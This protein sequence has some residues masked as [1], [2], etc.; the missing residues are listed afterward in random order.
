M[1]TNTAWGIQVC[2]CWKLIFTHA[3]Y[4]LLHHS[5]CPSGLASDTPK[6]RDFMLMYLQSETTL[7]SSGK[8][9]FHSHFSLEVPGVRLTGTPI[10][11]AILQLWLP[12][13]EDLYWISRVLSKKQ[14]FSCFPRIMRVSDIFFPFAVGLLFCQDGWTWQAWNKENQPS[15]P[16]SLP[17]D[18]LNTSVTKSLTPSQSSSI[19]NFPEIRQEFTWECQVRDST[20]CRNNGETWK[21]MMESW[22]R[23]P[24]HSDYAVAEHLT[25]EWLLKLCGQG[26][27]R[28]PCPWARHSGTMTHML[29]LWNRLV[30]YEQTTGTN[31][32]LQC[33]WF[34]CQLFIYH[35]IISVTTSQSSCTMY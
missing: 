18:D 20:G 10:T 12:D 35:C 26:G 23:E 21:E 29:G 4:S 24:R 33:L 1:N 17:S 19:P 8:Q 5:K 13:L 11:N 16:C 14:I 30:S 25:N 34:I 7:S 31:S 28:S 27:S 15:I 9:Q 6:L 22:E 32:A 3:I 2:L